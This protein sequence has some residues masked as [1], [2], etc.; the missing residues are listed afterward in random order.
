MKVQKNVKI[1]LLLMAFQ[2]G[3]LFLPEGLR[4]IIMP[5]FILTGFLAAI[6]SIISLSKNEAYSGIFI[7]ALEII[8][9]Y[10]VSFK[11]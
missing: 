2:F 9:A 3:I 7:L 4:F 8:V 6:F 10:W 1:A 11:P 5:V